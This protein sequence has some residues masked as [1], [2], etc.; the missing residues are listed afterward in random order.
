MI[1]DRKN[2][3]DNM[4]GKS[5]SILKPMI[6][7]NSWIGIPC[8]ILSWTVNT[9]WFPNTIRLMIKKIARKK[10]TKYLSRYLEIIVFVKLK[11]L[12]DIK[13]IIR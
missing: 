8:S 11:I 12:K 9:N 4:I 1:I 2:E 10:T 5:R 7:V 3:S 13:L 6:G